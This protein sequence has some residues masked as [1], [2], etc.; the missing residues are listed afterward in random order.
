M[1][2]QILLNLMVANPSVVWKSMRTKYSFIMPMSLISFEWNGSYGNAANKVFF[3]E[4]IVRDQL[5]S[6]DDKLIHFP[7]GSTG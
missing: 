4:I 5:E 3:I 1:E 7:Y 6:D 2:T